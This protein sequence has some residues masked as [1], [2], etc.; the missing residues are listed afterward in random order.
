[1]VGSVVLTF[2]GRQLAGRQHTI[3]ALEQVA[4]LINI[5]VISLQCV[6][7]ALVA[8]IRAANMV[9]GCVVSSVASPVRT[10]TPV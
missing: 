3:A 1:M 8:A 7:L 6:E 2:T 10:S 5:P 4:D 9:P